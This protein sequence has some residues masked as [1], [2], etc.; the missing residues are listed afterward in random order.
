MA[1]NS[2]MAWNSA[3]PEITPQPRAGLR[4]RSPMATAVH[5]PKRRATL[6]EAARRLTAE[7]REVFLKGL[8]IADVGTA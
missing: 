1:F 4:M 7:L 3:N 6:P 5:T 2:I 8:D